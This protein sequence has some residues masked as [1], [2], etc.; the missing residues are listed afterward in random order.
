MPLEINWSWD[1]FDFHATTE[2]PDLAKA[3]LALSIAAENSWERA[4][5]VLAELGFNSFA[6]VHYDSSNSFNNPAITL[7]SRIVD[8]QE[9]K[10]IIIALIVRGTTIDGHFWLTAPDVQTDIWSQINGFLDPGINTANVLDA[11]IEALR[12]ASI[13]D[14][15]MDN[16]VLFI[17]GH[18]L[19]G[20]VAAQTARL[21][22]TKYHR[23]QT[24]VYTF[25]APN[26][27]ANDENPITFPYVFQYM[28]MDDWVVHSP[29]HVNIAEW[30]PNPIDYKH[31]GNEIQFHGSSGN[32]AY[33]DSLWE[34]TGMP[35][36]DYLNTDAIWSQHSGSVYM[37]YLQS[38]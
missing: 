9:G 34:Y 36:D 1:K 29:V 37:A 21:L 11:Y 38:R 2:D 8:T 7:G 31:I 6:N 28:N 12:Q 16:T 4:D 25:A 18:S 3:G 24:Y 13:F 22:G 17:T 30:I 19:G 27:D 20:A 35:L 32:T 33:M 23:S 10:K 15:N 5:S 14:C 26:I